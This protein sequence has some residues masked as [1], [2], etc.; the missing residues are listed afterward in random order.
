MKTLISI[1]FLL[2]LLVFIVSCKTERKKVVNKFPDGKPASVIIYPDKADT[3]TYTIIWYHENGK[4][5]LQASIEKGKYVGEKKIYYHNGQL[6]QIDSLSQ[7]CDT[8]FNECD[9]L[10]IRYYENGNIS[11]R[12]TV[13]NNKLNGM[14]Q[15]FLK[16]GLLVKEYELKN[17]MTK[18]GVYREFHDN[19]KLSFE[20]NYQ[21][22]T[23]VGLGY[24]FN[25]KGDTVKYHNHYKGIISFPYKKWLDNG[26]ILFGD[27]TDKSEESV[28]WKWFDKN[29]RQIKSKVAYAKVEG[30]VAP[31]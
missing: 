26:N 19:G 24:Y 22:D 11:Q 12:Y 23:V 18:N 4:I 6:K 7:P 25:E 17:G 31:E 21:N 5:A 1:N 2:F 10:L 3:T 8:I 9:G 20:C 27:Y 28:Y 15:H 13:R 29:G 30:F 14:S 16:N